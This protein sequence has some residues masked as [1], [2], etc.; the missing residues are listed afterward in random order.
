[1]KEEET[2][3]DK[4]EKTLIWAAKNKYFKFM[5]KLINKIETKLF[6]LPIWDKK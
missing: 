6:K 1:M 5:N 2:Y 4:K 3:T